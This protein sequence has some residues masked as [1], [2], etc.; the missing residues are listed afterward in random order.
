MNLHDRS[1][2]KMKSQSE[3]IVDLN[4][5]CNGPNQFENF[6]R[7]FRATLTVPKAAALKEEARLKRAGAR[8]KRAKKPQ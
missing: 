8:T 7:L 4:A 2:A 5:R 6:D 3:T 1:D